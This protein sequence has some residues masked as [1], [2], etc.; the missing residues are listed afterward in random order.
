[1]GFAS[2]KSKFGA[3]G[4]TLRY[5]REY[6]IHDPYVGSD[7]LVDLY[8]FESVIVE[9]ENANAVLK[10]SGKTAGMQAIQTV[11]KASEK[12]FAAG[13]RSGTPQVNPLTE[14]LTGC[15]L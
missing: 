5:S 11:K 8:K 10:K 1:M 15:E 9:D 13:R 2:Y 14:Q 7:H 12:D 3:V 4:S 6:V